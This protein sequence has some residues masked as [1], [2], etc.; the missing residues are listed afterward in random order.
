MD[1]ARQVV[2]W[3]IPGWVFLLIL[4]VL[5]VVTWLIQGRSAQNILQSSIPLLT[6]AAVA[7]VLTA[8]VPLGFILYQIYYSWYGKVLLFGFVNRDRGA[9]ILQE[10]PDAVQQTLGRIAG[11]NPDLEEMDERVGP[12]LL[13]YPFRRLKRE[14]RNKIGKTRFEAKVHANWELIRF[15]M[16]RLCI[17]NKADLI[18]SEIITLADI[19]HGIGAA[20][21]ALFLACELHLLLNLTVIRSKSTLPW[22]LVISILAPYLLALWLFRVFERTRNSALRSHLSVLSL[23]LKTFPVTTTTDSVETPGPALHVG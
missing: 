7:S 1:T 12:F 9:S 6:P 5:Q 17:I 16:L 13:P 14:H 22:R 19:Y 15:M 10:L 20:R 11:V 3:S 8:G 23:A 4:A 21:A 18:R 2:R